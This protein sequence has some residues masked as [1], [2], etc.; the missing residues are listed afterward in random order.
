M[1]EKK[2]ILPKKKFL[3]KKKNKEYNYEGEREIFLS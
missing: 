3:L 2:K 1:K